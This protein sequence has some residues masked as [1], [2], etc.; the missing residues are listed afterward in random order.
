M[1]VISVGSC[2]KKLQFSIPAEKVR[3]EFDRA[4]RQLSGRV[5][6]PGFRPGKAPRKVLEMRF[7]EQIVS[8]VAST[9][10]QQGYTDAIEQHKLEP[11]GR[12]EIDQGDLRPSQDF[13]FSIT[14]DIKPEVELSA[15][16]GLEV[17]YPRVEVGDDEVEERVHTRLEGEA[18]LVE[19]TARPAEKGD[20]VLVQLLAKD[21]DEVVAEEM[22]TMI[23]TDGDPYYPGVDE[24]V[25]G[26]EVD[27]E[28]TAQVAFPDTARTEGVAG[29]SLE[30]M[31]KVISIQA[32]EIP[33]L[34]DEL[35]AELG[36]EG[37]TEGLRLALRAEIAQAREEAARNQARANVLQ[38]LIE[39]NAFDVPQGMVEEQLKALMEELKLQAA[40][41]GQDPRSVSFTEE[42]VADLRV[43]A[44]FAVKGGL[45]LEYVASKEGLEVIDADL[46]AKY[47]DLADD[48]GQSVEAIK[49][50]FVRDGVEDELRS[51]LL[52]EKT[53]DFLLEKSK[54]VEP[55]EE[56]AAEAAPA[57][58]EVDLTV[59]A[60]K[61]ADV[62]AAVDSGVH[63]AHLE[64]LLA[65]EEAGKA[66]K[67]VVKALRDRM[68]ALA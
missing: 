65:A 26:L 52:E 4:Y 41:R 5:R 21:G 25:V 37:G 17:P 29:K 56:P 55:K 24:L 36:Y 62:K 57:S 32:T 59:L 31:V 40:Y 10:I 68:A 34:T 12:P 15:Y 23:R 6:L 46:E 11:V 42:Q 8:D 66:R 39:H 43:R 22:G 47:Q 7:G 60:G 35:A 13:E 30:V 58:E 27:A 9:L 44:E 33:E 19:V 16:G 18:R 20:M 1:D 49:G 50:Y 54:L 61:V 63:D 48:R 38:V 45:I 51:R 3:E 53:L 14:V 67:G 2:Q 64:T 28:K